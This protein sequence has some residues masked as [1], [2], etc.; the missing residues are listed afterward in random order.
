MG[1]GGGASEVYSPFRA[2][3]KGF[4]LDQGKRGGTKKF[5]D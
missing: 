2:G 5:E 3:Q 4:T 1:G